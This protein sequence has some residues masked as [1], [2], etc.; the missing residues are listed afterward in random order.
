[1]ASSATRATLLIKYVCRWRFGI[2][3]QA[4]LFS[5]S[6]TAPYVMGQ[7]FGRF[8]CSIRL[9]DLFCVAKLLLFSEL[10]IIF[11]YFFV[12]LCSVMVKILCT[13]PLILD[14][15]MGS[16]LQKY[17]FGKEDFFV[18]QFI[19]KGCN[20]VGCYDLLSVTRPDIIRKVHSEYVSA[21]A[22]IITTNTFN[23]NSVSLKCF[24]LEDFVHEINLAGA[25][26]AA[27]VV[28]DVFEHSGRVVAVAG[29]MGPSCE[30]LSR[31]DVSS[32]EVKFNSLAESYSE[33]ACALIRGGVDLLLLETIIDI[34]NM[35]AA[36]KGI[37]SAFLSTGK[38]LPLMLSFS[39]DINGRILSGESIDELV[40]VSK[41]AGA[42]CVGLNCGVGVKGMSEYLRRMKGSGLK[43]AFYPSAGLPDAK[44][45]YSLSAE[46]FADIIKEY[47]DEGTVDIIG[48]C[49]GTTP[50]YI[51]AIARHF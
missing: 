30:L 14:G 50:E 47:V 18:P 7:P 28:A 46:E 36:L 22:D 27:D 42:F 38:R 20:P 3:F 45:Q 29:S 26:V 5:H 48:G 16:V 44:G 15:A 51:S 8:R 2:A 9:S 17:N 1:S 37:E 39:V 41:Q 40:C 43:V 34:H 24:G 35:R 25:R 11:R 10:T 32:F 19:I 33:Q 49:C 6:S 23:A 4:C 13:R 21:D 12:I 31:V